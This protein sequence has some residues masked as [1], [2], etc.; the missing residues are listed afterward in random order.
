MVT[1]G[2]SWQPKVRNL[3]FEWTIEK[4]IFRFQISVR[5]THLA[6]I[7]NS[8]DEL[9][10]IGTNGLRGEGALLWKEIEELSTF[11]QFQDNQW[12]FF[13]GLISNLDVGLNTMVNNVDE[14]G[15]VK[16]REEIYFDF[17]GLL[18]SRAGKIDLE[19]VE[20]VVLAA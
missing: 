10:G 14:M 4:N 11:C 17:K 9:L 1:F 5:Y 8:S 20:G 19:C 12:S 13:F 2:L 15:E 7:P 6:Q 16:F 3:K 18:F